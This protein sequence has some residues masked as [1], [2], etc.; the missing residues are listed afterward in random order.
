MPLIM[1]TSGMGISLTEDLRSLCYGIVLN[2]LLGFLSYFVSK[3]S[4]QVL[5]GSRYGYNF[6]GNPKYFFLY[7]YKQ[8]KD[9]NPIWIT[10]NDK[11]FQRL[12]SEGLPVVYRYSWEGF[13]AILKS[14]FLIFDHSAREVSYSFFLPGRFKK[15]NS[16]HGGSGIK[17]MKVSFHN[18]FDQ[19]I[20]RNIIKKI[21]KHER[22]SYQT[23]LTCSNSWKEKYSS[24]FGEKCIKVLGYPKNDL[25]FDDSRVYQDYKTILKLEKF[26]KVIL[27]CPTYRE[28]FRTQYPFSNKF[29]KKLN[30]FLVDR[31]YVFLDKR[32]LNEHWNGGCSKFSNIVDI[33][34]TVEDIMDLLFHVDILITDYSSA[35]A[36]FSLLDK[37]IIFYPYDYEDYVQSQGMMIDY[38]KDLPGPFAMNENDLSVCIKNVYKISRNGEYQKK[39]QTL[40]NK[41][42]RYQD[43]Q[44]CKRLYDFL[45]FDVQKK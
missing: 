7:L 22:K 6:I 1:N 31:N 27:Y 11:V 42:H 12:E 45:K 4:N 30:E 23:V 19:I 37:P 33:T 15:I 8:K 2:I 28:N 17:T 32:H 44:S 9:V 25:F 40:K 5:L 18:R 24:I 41:L 29:L 16:W 34:N 35:V 10:S 36:D 38:F 26:D 21:I 43:G 3:K 39:Y 14:N 20:L 13:V